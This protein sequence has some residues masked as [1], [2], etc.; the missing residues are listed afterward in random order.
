VGV[1]LSLR[2]L[3]TATFLSDVTRGSFQLYALR[4]TGYSNDDPDFFDYVFNSAKVPPDG[5]NRGH[6]HN[7]ELDKLLD[8]QRVEMDMQKRK[9]ILSQIQKIV[10]EDEPYIDLWYVDNV[11][12]YRSRVS[13]IA[14]SPGGD[15]DFLENVGLARAPAH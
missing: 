13:G 4:W 12:V 6:Y 1:D 9:A 10:A 8:A 7:P 11:C 14:L 15:Y 5:A 3:E 2:P